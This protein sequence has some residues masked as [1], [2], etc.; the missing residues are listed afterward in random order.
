MS[1]EERQCASCEKP[2]TPEEAEQTV[3]PEC[4]DRRTAMWVV[5]LFVLFF[6]FVALPMMIQLFGTPRPAR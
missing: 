2:F 4:H 1:G 6:C 5:G 3:C